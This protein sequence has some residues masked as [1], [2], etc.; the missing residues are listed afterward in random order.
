M[1]AKDLRDM[2]VTELVAKEKDLR[3]ESFKLRFQ[4]A[5]RQLEN[6]AGLRKVRRDIAK[7]LT[8]ISEKEAAG[9]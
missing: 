2:S 3:E 4:K 7:V 9:A 5:T 1:N 6:T 8:V